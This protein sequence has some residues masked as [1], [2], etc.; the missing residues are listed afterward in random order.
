MKKNLAFI[1]LTS[2]ILPFTGYYSWLTYQKSNAKKE[3][4]QRIIAGLHKTELKLLVFSKLDSEVKLKWEHAHEFEYMHQMYDVI[5]TEIHG[6]SLYYFC[7]ADN[8]ETLL[9]K[10]LNQL[11]ASVM[12]NPLKEN[13]QH[14]QIIDFY[15]SLSLPANIH[16]PLLNTFYLELIFT[17]YPFWVINFFSS[18]PS[19]P[20]KVF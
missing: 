17:I 16:I 7:W 11:L 12:A 8:E 4:K 9:N 5:E 3:I 18:I 14:K 20:P 2:I 19:P 13:K 6:D 1:L 10:K 15:K